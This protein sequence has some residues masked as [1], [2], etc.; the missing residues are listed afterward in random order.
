M[1]KKIL[2]KQWV[3]LLCVE[4]VVIGVLIGGIALAVRNSDESDRAANGEDIVQVNDRLDGVDNKLDQVIEQV[5]NLATTTT[6]APTTTIAVTT[7]TTTVEKVDDGNDT[8]REYEA[9]GLQKLAE[10]EIPDGAFFQGSCV[11]DSQWGMK[12]PGKQGDAWTPNIQFGPITYTDYRFRFTFNADSDVVP[13]NL[14]HPAYEDALNI[15]DMWP[16]QVVCRM[17]GTKSLGIFVV[18]ELS[19]TL[20]ELNPEFIYSGWQ[21]SDYGQDWSLEDDGVLPYQDG[22]WS[23]ARLIKAVDGRC[24]G[25]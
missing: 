19:I 14:S 15:N 20:H 16:G 10:F 13:Y 12:F 18:G 2:S 17:W 5:E 11:G 8:C 24:P 21:E 4:L 1:F 9:N 7:P 6:T 25:D 22:T 23:V 3:Q